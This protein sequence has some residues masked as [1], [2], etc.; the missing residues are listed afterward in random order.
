[1]DIMLNV[2]TCSLTIASWSIFASPLFTGIIPR[3][4]LN[5]YPSMYRSA[6]AFVLA[7][8]GEGW[9]RPVRRELQ[10]TPQYRRFLLCSKNYSRPPQ[11]P[12][13]SGLGGRR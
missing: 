1:M 11:C 12:R 7:T 6:D 2:G 8:H 5:D 10:L 13:S 9:G 4:S 3:Q